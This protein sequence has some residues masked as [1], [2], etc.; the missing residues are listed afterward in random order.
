MAIYQDE[1]KAVEIK[2]AW[3][4]PEMNKLTVRRMGFPGGSDCKESTCKVGDLG[5]NPWVRK[6]PWRRE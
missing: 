1:F 5:F 4:W 3:H 6:I 2:P